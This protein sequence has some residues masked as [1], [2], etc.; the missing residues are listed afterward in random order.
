MIEISIL[1]TIQD[2]SPVSQFPSQ[3]RPTIFYRPQ[4]VGT[5]AVAFFGRGKALH[6]VFPGTLDDLIRVKRRRGPLF[7]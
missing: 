7:S 4:K 3:L 1:L 6:L 2:V 5:K